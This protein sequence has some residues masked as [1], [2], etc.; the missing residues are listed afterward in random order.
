MIPHNLVD[1]YVRM[2][3]LYGAFPHL[4]LECERP[5]PGRIAVYEVTDEYDRARTAAGDR[6]FE[7]VAENA[8]VGSTVLLICGPEATAAVAQ[9][10]ELKARQGFRFG[11][12]GPASMDMHLSASV[13]NDRLIPISGARL[14]CVQLD[15]VVNARRRALYKPQSLALINHRDPRRCRRIRCKT[16]DGTVCAHAIDKRPEAH[17]GALNEGRRRT[18]AP[19]AAKRRLAI[20]HPARSDA[21]VEDLQPPHDDAALA[22]QDA[23]DVVLFSK[24]VFDVET[25]HVAMAGGRF[26]GPFE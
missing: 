2:H 10:Y 11:L 24:Q 1:R 25:Q 3:R 14:E 9:G 21:V 13:H 7:Q 17:G 8:G 6:H 12:E 23:A 26:S 4:E 18:L 15:F 22:L 19:V 20:N 5:R 16:N